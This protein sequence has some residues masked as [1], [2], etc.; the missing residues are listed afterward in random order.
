MMVNLFI[1]KNKEKVKEWQSQVKF[2]HGLLQSLTFFKHRYHITSP[3]EHFLIHAIITPFLKPMV[4]ISTCSVAFTFLFTL[5]LRRKYNSRLIITRFC[6]KMSAGMPCFLTE[7]VTFVHGTFTTA[8]EALTIHHGTVKLSCRGGASSF[9]YLSSWD[10]HLQSV[11][12]SRI[13]FFKVIR[14]SC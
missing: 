2:G 11:R 7:N 8:Y 10:K 14:R 13:L 3:D 1:K 12:E 9:T 4:Y 6:R 5:F